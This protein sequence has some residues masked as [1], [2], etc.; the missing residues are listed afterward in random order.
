MCIVDLPNHYN[1]PLCYITPT[2]SGVIS[3]ILR[4]ENAKLLIVIVLQIVDCDKGVDPEPL[5]AI[6]LTNYRL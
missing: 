2:S 5:I 1:T 6:D 3:Q 4:V